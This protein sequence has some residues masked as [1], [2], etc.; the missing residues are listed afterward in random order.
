MATVNIQPASPE[1]SGTDQA[2]NAERSLRQGRV[3]RAI[4]QFEQ[5][6]GLNLDH[7]YAGIAALR[8]TES[9]LRAGKFA[10]ARACFDHLRHSGTIPAYMDELEIGEAI[11]AYLDRPTPNTREKLIRVRAR[12]PSARLT[13]LAGSYLNRYPHR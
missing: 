9:Y 1:R 7:P 2:L 6:I 13:V 4:S 10:M 8:L 12:F 3:D 5:F 11:F